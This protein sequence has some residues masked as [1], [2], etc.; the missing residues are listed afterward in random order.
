MGKNFI[1]P[2]CEEIVDEEGFRSE[3]FI[4]EFKKS[5]LC[6]DCLDIVFGYRVAW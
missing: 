6:Q 2:L 1:C 4:G 3:A 5:G